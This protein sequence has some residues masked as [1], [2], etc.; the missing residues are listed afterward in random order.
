MLPERPL[1]AVEAVTARRELKQFDRNAIGF[2]GRDKLAAVLRRYGFVINGMSEKCGR[3]AGRNLRLIGIEL[4][5]FGLR[6]GPKEFVPGAGVRVFAHRDD[7][8]DEPGEIRPATDSLDGI[9]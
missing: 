5:E 7:W 6:I 3:R 8:I 4:D 1:A 9:G 2:H